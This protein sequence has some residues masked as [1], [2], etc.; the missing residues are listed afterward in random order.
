M[1]LAARI[2]A[3]IL[4]LCIGAILGLGILMAG[5]YL[6]RESPLFNKGDGVRTLLCFTEDDVLRLNVE[7]RDEGRVALFQTPQGQDV[8]LTFKGGGLFDDVYSDGAVEIRID[9]EVYVTGIH[10]APIRPCDWE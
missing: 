7:F 8:R 3:V 2:F 4:L 10:P 1:L 5:G 9:P 6:S